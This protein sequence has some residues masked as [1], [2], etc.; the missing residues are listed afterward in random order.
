MVSNDG[1]RRV[2]ERVNCTSTRTRATSTSYKY[3]TVTVYP[4]TTVQVKCTSTRLV[5]LPIPVQPYS[6]SRTRVDKIN[7][8]YF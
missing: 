5:E 6:C 4:Q 2:T 3:G 8:G 7:E 1:D